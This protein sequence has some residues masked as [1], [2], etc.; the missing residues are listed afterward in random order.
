MVLQCLCHFPLFWHIPLVN[1]DT[2]QL[3]GGGGGVWGQY[4]E[5]V[6][7]KYGV[8]LKSTILGK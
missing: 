2:Q 8:S 5:P 6:S 3:Q 4:D 7:F 1:D